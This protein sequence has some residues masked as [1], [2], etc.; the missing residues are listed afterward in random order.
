MINRF[1]TGRLFIGAATIM[2]AACQSAPA[3]SAMEPDTPFTLHH[4]TIHERGAVFRGTGNEPGWVVEI[5]REQELS[6][7]G[8]YGA[9][10]FHAPAQPRHEGTDDAVQYS[11]TQGEHHLRLRIQEHRCDD[12]MSD[13]EYP[14]TVTVWLD[15][16]ELRGCGWYIN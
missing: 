3:P 8:D 16:R 15:E 13:D 5:N 11:G 12:T 7:V 1:V 10:T 9:F 6:F 4:A 2:L 14:L